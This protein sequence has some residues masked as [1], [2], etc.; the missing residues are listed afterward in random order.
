[1]ILKKE[2]MYT[3]HL[4]LKSFNLDSLSRTENYLLSL[5]FFLGGGQVKHKN[6]P[7]KC[8][9]ITVLR[10]PHIDKKSREQF[11]RLTHKKTLTVFFEKKST[12]F[13]FFE[14]LKESKTRGVE[15]EIITEF[16]TY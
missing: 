4:S 2:T 11:Q 1:M 16:S 12:L 13:L 10:S 14:F 3:I 15:I 8:Q 5:F 9:K 6:N 7:Q